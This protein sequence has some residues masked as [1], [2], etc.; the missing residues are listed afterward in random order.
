[1]TESLIETVSREIH[2]KSRPV[3]MPTEENF[4]IATISLPPPGAGQMLF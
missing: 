1:M 2:L 3:G 4:E